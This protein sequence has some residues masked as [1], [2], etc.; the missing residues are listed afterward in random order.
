MF[1]FGRNRLTDLEN[2]LTVARGKAGG[3]DSQ[4]AWNGH[5]DSAIF[6][7]GNKMVLLPSTWQPGREGVW[8][9]TDTCVCVA[10]SLCCPPDAITTLFVNRL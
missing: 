2:E 3:K 8:G 7:V 10:E 9:R 6:T 1:R 4:G 5:I